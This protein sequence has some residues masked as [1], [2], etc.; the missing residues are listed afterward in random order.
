MELC[1]VDCGAGL[2]TAAGGVACDERT[3]DAVGNPCSPLI[4]PPDQAAFAIAGNDAMYALS[5]VLPPWA[6]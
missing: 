3:T 1:R 6:L 2:S 4:V 5:G